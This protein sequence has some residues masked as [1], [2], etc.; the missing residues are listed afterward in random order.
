MNQPWI[1]MYSPS[2]SPFPPS[3]STRSLWVLPVHQ[4]RALVSCIQPGLVICFTIDNIHAV[5]L[6]YNFTG[7]RFLDN[8]FFFFQHFHCFTS[9]CSP[10]WF[11]RSQMKSSCLILYRQV[12]FFL[13]VCFYIWKIFSSFLISCS[14]NVMCLGVCVCVYVCIYMCVCICVCVCVCVCVCIHT[15]SF[16]LPGVL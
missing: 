3:L 14:L 7:Y 11:L 1:Y 9:L 4:A 16:I 13:F 15:L 10:A 8:D 12:F 2:Q 6:K 5:I